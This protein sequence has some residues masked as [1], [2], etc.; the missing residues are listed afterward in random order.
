MSI[1]KFTTHTILGASICFALFFLCLGEFKLL[2]HTLGPIAALILV[3]VLDAFNWKRS[4]QMLLILT[5]SI[6]L[7]HFTYLLG[8]ESAI[9]QLFII[10]S[11]IPLLVFNKKQ[12]ALKMISIVVT[13]GS[14]FVTEWVMFF[15][16]PLIKMAPISLKLISIFSMVSVIGIGLVIIQYFLKEKDTYEAH[17]MGL[18]AQL[19][20]TNKN[21]VSTNQQLKESRDMQERLTQHAEYAKL[22][23]SIAH[24][25]KNPLQMIQGTAE[26]GLEK[27]SDRSES[28]AIILN[29]IER[30][31]NVIQPLLLY[32]NKHP[33]SYMF[34]SHDI[35]SLVQDIYVLSKANCKSKRI[36]FTIK[37]D[38]L[39]N[40]FI[41][42]DQQSIGQVLI[43]LIT[44]SIDAISHESG[45][46]T[47]ELTND[48][49]NNE[50]GQREAVLICVTDN[51][52]GIDSETL[53]TI[54]LPYQS[55]NKGAENLGLGLSIVAKIM[56][57]HQGVMDIASTKGAGTTVS[58]WL[59]NHISHEQTFN[60][61]SETN[62]P[63]FEL[64]DSFFEDE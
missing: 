53:K 2:L 26:V 52:S 45:K 1:L 17:L 44:N 18:N 4:A 23:Q 28:F 48:V 41:M 34:M 43:N 13:L 5:V 37:Q 58:L 38:T 50:K 24:E 64:N 12:R 57:D 56:N 31:N 16:S 9:Y 20:E 61:E 29:G 3:I 51:G 21:L 39:M 11:F 49:I 25:I 32:L 40:R 14:Y 30:L 42:A 10:I 60:V 35:T 55:Y 59:P 8:K 19:E 62:K 36:E 46:I 22:V 63:L 33:K 27:E 15:K 7:I 6:A 47:I 54:G